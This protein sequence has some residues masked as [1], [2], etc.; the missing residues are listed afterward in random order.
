[1]DPL[2][3]PALHRGEDPL[4][5]AARER[6]TFQAVSRWEVRGHSCSNFRKFS[7]GLPRG[8]RGP[9]QRWVRMPTST[10]FPSGHSAS[11]AAFAVAVGDVL[12]ELRAA[13]SVGLLP[14][15]HRSALPRRRHHRRS[16]ERGVGAGGSGLGC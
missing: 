6:G 8:P 14:R 5:G 11:A 10:S 9:K 3:E 4:P 7:S 12:P 1:V 13:G 16:G 2:P 15:L